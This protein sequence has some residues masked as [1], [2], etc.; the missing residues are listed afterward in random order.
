MAKTKGELIKCN[1]EAFKGFVKA[2]IISVKV[3]NDYNIYSL[4]CQMP[5]D[6]GKMQKYSHIASDLKVSERLVMEA[7][8]S[9]KKPI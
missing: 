3:N 6:I 4:Y 1:Y 8:R 9:M 2:G 5:K 7:V